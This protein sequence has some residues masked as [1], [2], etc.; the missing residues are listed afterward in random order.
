[1]WRPARQRK[2]VVAVGFAIMALLGAV[3]AHAS[4]VRLL[5]ECGPPSQANGT[6]TLA[7]G[8]RATGPAEFQA[9]TARIEGEAADLEMRFEPFDAERDGSTT[10]YLVQT[11]PAARRATLGQM[12]DAV[13]T[14]ADR[15]EGQRRFTAYTFAEGLTAV[16]NS[17]VSRDAFVR[18]LIAIRPASGSTHLYASARA[19]VEALAKETGARKSLVILADG[20]SDDTDVTHDEVVEAARD[21]G[22][23]IHVL[24][25]YDDA[26]QRSKFEALSRLA[27][28]TGGYAAEV[29][30]GAGA[31]N[32]FTKEI[33]TSRFLTDIVENGGMVTAALSG[34]AGTRKV[35]FTATLLDDKSLST[36]AE[37]TI[38]AAAAPS[39]TP[40]HVELAE[41]VATPA[42][43]PDPEPET[44]ESEGRSWLLVLALGAL[45]ALGIAGYMVLGKDLFQFVRWWIE[46]E[47]RAVENTGS[48][49]AA[50]APTRQTPA[51]PAPTPTPTPTAAPTAAPRASTPSRQRHPGGERRAVVY[52]W[53]EALDG[54]AARHPLR[55]TDVR[56]GRHR[57]N[58]I[59]LTNDSISRRHAAVRYDAKTRRF[60][61]TDLGAG[62]GVIV[63]KTRCTS[64]E[65]NDGDTVELGEV[66]LRFRAEPGFQ[67]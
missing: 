40:A 21:A 37:V 23:T 5:A 53:L 34:P 16:S 17:G 41:P 52:G 10:A 43:A 26:R 2:A 33:V 67:S 49:T 30:R 9:V 58:D 14:I 7:C 4:E 62:N 57:D 13:A 15:R 27:E 44:V 66:R 12:A 64:R 29:K 47:P 3:G 1:M 45:G 25:Y 28:E 8:L 48:D 32:D 60:T 22:V 61:I 46:A 42:P 24:G 56:V 31:K 50:R 59:C 63:N 36:E 55:S 6:R 54:D 39:P 65:L 20:T 18:Q 19:A 51:L 35:A 38:P 11:L